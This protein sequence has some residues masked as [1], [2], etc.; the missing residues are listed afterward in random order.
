MVIDW[1]KLPAVPGMRP[2]SVRRGICADQIS[3]VQIEVA[4]D[5]EFDGKTH[6]HE[7]EQILVVVSGFCKIVIDGQTMTARQGDLVFFPSKSR[8]AVIGTGPEGCV[9]YELFAPA[10]PDQLPGWVGSSPLRFD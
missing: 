3:A 5:A 6:W 4:A 8:H 10:R 1:S 7:H 9:Y 2:G